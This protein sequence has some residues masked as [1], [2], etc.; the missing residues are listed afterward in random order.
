MM[1]CALYALYSGFAV[2]AI[3]GIVFAPVVHRVFHRFHIDEEDSR[4]K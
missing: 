3:A 4:K 1:F 2:L